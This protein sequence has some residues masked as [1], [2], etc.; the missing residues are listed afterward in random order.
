MKVIVLLAN[1]LVSAAMAAALPTALVDARGCFLDKLDKRNNLNCNDGPPWARD[2]EGNSAIVARGCF[3]AKRNNLNCN[4]G[5]PWARDV[6]GNSAIV[7]RGCFL[8]KRKNLNC[9]DGPPWA[10]DVQEDSAENV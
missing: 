5:P 4:D 3:L 2:V 8:D 7:P 1:L 6:E 10:R 9:N